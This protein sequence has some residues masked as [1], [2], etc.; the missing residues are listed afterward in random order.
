MNQKNVSTQTAKTSPDQGVSP[1][2]P[3]QLKLRNQ[4]L[5]QANDLELL[6]TFKPS[7]LKEHEKSARMKRLTLASR[8]MK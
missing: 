2:K 4:G 6:R 1:A 3:A 5:L 7:F 8:L